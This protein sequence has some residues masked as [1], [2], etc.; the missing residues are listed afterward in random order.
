MCQ[1]GRRIL[2][3]AVQSE[4]LNLWLFWRGECVVQVYEVSSEPNL[5]IVVLR[6]LSIPA[7]YDSYRL[8]EE[9][10]PGHFFVGVFG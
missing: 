2:R 8:S 5:E 7:W 1:V 3:E 10:T 6:L 4:D 9:S